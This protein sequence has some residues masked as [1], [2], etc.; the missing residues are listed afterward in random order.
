MVAVWGSCNWGWGRSSTAPA[1][2]LGHH[3]DWQQ[4]SASRGRSRRLM[5]ED[6]SM[7]VALDETT[8]S[9]IGDLLPPFRRPWQ[10]L[11]VLIKAP[12][13][14]GSTQSADEERL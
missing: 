8:R 14:Q 3:W 7:W 12:P 9:V 11:R 6:D 13:G 5:S 10:T 1:A 2:E 4:G